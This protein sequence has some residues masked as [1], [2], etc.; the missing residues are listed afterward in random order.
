MPRWL[1]GWE[2]KAGREGDDWWLIILVVMHT[3][4]MTLVVCSIA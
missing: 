1:R 3:S 4:M 2:G